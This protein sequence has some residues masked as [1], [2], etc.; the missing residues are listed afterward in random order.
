MKISSESFF[1]KLKSK[2][3][4]LDS[5]QKSLRL[6][7]ER[8]IKSQ[9]ETPKVSVTDFFGMNQKASLSPSKKLNMGESMNIIKKL[10]KREDGGPIEKGEPYLVGE[11]GPEIVTPDHDGFVI[12]NNQ[13]E[14]L[15]LN[16]NS[17]KILVQPI[18]KEVVQ[19]Q[20]VPVPVPKV[21]S[22]TKIIKKIQSLQSIARMIK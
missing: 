12:P 11:K 18:T 17:T 6:R 8:L 2:S 13:I 16:T 4:F 3:K 21:V 22:K 1:S 10:T 15:S 20:R 7:E 9:S 19:K 5:R 14:S